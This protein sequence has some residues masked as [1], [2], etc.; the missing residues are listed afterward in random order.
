MYKRTALR[1]HQKGKDLES[2]SITY[3]PYLRIKLNLSEIELALCNEKAA[4][5]I[6]G[7]LLYDEGHSASIGRLICRECC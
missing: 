7:E 6:L 5:R 2:D 4:K 1:I 3:L